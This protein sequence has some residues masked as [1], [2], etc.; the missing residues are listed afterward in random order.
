V[1]GKIAEKVG[2]SCVLCGLALLCPIADIVSRIILRGKVRDQKGIPG[3]VVMDCLTVFFCF[4]CS[5]CQEAQEVGALD[6]MAQSM[7]RE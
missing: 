2:E 4:P 7:A 6:N 3:G 1:Q 5:I